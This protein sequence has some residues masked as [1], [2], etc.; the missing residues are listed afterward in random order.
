MNLGQI[1]SRLLGRGKTQVPPATAVEPPTIRRIAI[2]RLRVLPVGGGPATPKKKLTFLCELAGLGYA[3]DNPELYDDSALDDYADA[4]KI[5][6]A[7]RGGGVDYVPLFQGFPTDMPE[8]NEY[9]VRRLLGYVGTH[10]QLFDGGVALLDGRLVPEWLFDLKQFGADPITQMQ[11][12]G[13]FE[14]GK[15][16]QAGRQGDS[17]TVWVHLRFAGPE[18]FGQR[19]LGFL[20]GNLY[21]RSSIQESL[22]ADLEFLL[23]VFPHE[24]IEASRVVFK[25]TRTLV[26]KF[27]WTRG[28]F[29]ALQPYCQTPT[30]LLRLMAALTGSDISLEQPI[31]FP[32]LRRPQRV[33][34]LEA[35]SRCS[36]LGPDLSRYRGLWIALARSLHVG[37]FHK[38]FPVVVETFQRLRQGPI[39]G[40][41]SQFEAALAKGEVQSILPLLVKNPGVFGRRLHHLLDVA[42]DDFAVVLEAFRG[43]AGQLT[44]KN[45]LVMQAFFKTIEDGPYRTVINK[46]G[47]IRVL[48]NRRRRLPP[49]AMEGLLALLHAAIL[50]ELKTRP[51]WS[52]RRIWIDPRLCNYTVPLQQRKA[53]EGLLVLGRGSKVPLETGK[54]LRLFVYWKEKVG[55]TDLDLS[56]IQYGPELNFVGQVSYTRLKGESVVH[57]GDIQSAPHGAAEFIDVDLE[58]LSQ[59]K[60]CRYLA[61]QIYR[62]AGDYFSVMQCHAGW[63]LRDKIDAQYKTFDIKTV[64]NKFDLVGTSGYAIPIIV[65]LWDKEITFVDLY[66]SGK[67]MENAVEGAVNDISLITGEMVR[68]LKTRPNIHELCLYHAR[69]RGGD[70]VDRKEEADLTFGLTDCTYNV[71]ASERILSELL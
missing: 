53:S 16:S 65:D 11:D 61:P 4:I 70:L 39:S 15:K 30:D 18:E 26:M 41:D 40:V 51:S 33:F 69:G 45:L 71:S 17:N 48:D 42:G 62:F 36:N 56:L 52:G 38:R 29:T 20:K 9:F 8:E 23:G 59:D 50:Q 63:M 54:V 58:H 37:E 32:K 31:K 35:L 14:A 27:W 7:M 64:Q 12:R 10:C 57:S 67:T 28:D 47:R 6:Q 21:A 34:L 2:E 60:S 66:M 25:E 24:E 43:V 3:V 68:M 44:L 49:P 46:K 13:L 55:R 5:L 1:L 19:A 22:H